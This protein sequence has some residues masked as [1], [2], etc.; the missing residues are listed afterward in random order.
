MLSSF[1]SL[2]SIRQEWTT[3]WADTHFGPPNTL[4]F[5]N[6]NLFH[7]Y[8]FESELNLLLKTH[9]TFWTL[10]SSEHFT[11]QHTLILSTLWSSAHFDPQQPLLPGTLYFLEHFALSVPGAKYVEEEKLPGSKMFQGAE[12]SKTQ[13]VLGSK[14]FQGAEYNGVNSFWQ[15]S[16]ILIS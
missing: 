9:S 6:N 1:F 4:L 8:W 12:C 11:P 15:D 2:A 16:Y 10:Y 7:I 13:S 5:G 14:V 3:I